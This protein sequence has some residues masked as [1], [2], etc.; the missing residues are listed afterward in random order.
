[1][2]LLAT[3]NCRNVVVVVM[4][5]TQ[6]MLKVCPSPSL[7]QCMLFPQSFSNYSPLSA[8]MSSKWLCCV[9]CHV[10]VVYFTAHSKDSPCRIAASEQ[11]TLTTLATTGS[12][13]IGP[14]L[15]MMNSSLRSPF[16]TALTLANFH[17]R[18]AIPPSRLLLNSA[19]M[20]PRIP[21]NEI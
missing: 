7:S 15:P 3:S 21:G 20:L 14:K 5:T 2:T 10:C 8:I 9:M 18:G 13:D 16:G 19:V 4:V 6:C 1:M 17:T 12:I 11:C